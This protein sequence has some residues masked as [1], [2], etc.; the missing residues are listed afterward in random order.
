VIKCIV[1]LTKCE[2]SD[3]S[4][5]QVLIEKWFNTV[6]CHLGQCSQGGDSTMWMWLGKPVFENIFLPL[7][8]EKGSF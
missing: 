5:L 1:F 3:V 7:K 4:H 2:P 6:F 8:Q